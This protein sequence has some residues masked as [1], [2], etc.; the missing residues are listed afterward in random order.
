MAD[1]ICRTLR[2]GGLE[3][4]HAPALTINDTV[5]CPLGSFVFDHILAQL[6]SFI[7]SKK[8]NSK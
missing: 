5:S 3:G 4:E 6:S 1:W 7:S 2:D 8:S